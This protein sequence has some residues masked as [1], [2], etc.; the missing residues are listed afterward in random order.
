MIKI[1]RADK[2]TYISNFVVDEVVKDD[3]NVGIAGS[4]NL[5]KLYGHSMS[6]S[7]PLT[8]L[9]RILLHFNLEP[10][11]SLVL[12]GTV[13]TTHSSFQCLLQLRDVYGG[14]PVP[15]SYGI[16]V[17]PLSASFDEGLGKDVVLYS[18]SDEANWLSGSRN[19]P[20][21]TAGC[22]LAGHPD[23]SCDYITGSNA[24]GSLLSTQT[25]PV[26]TEDLSIDVTRI[27][28]GM[29]SNQLPD[30]GFRLSFTSAQEADTATYFVK[31]FGSRQAYNEA[32]RPTL[33]VKFDDSVTDDAQNLTI[34]V[35][36][37]VHLYNYVYGQLT[38]L[39]SSSAQLTGNNVASLR[40]IMEVSGGFH[41]MSFPV[42]QKVIGTSFVSGT[43]YANIVVP[44]SDTVIVA[45]LA[46]SAS[47]KFTPVWSSTDETVSFHTG[48]LLTVKK[49]TT[50][51]PSLAPKK[52]AVSVVGLFDEHKTTDVVPLRLN[53]FDKVAISLQP[54]KKPIDTP[55]L[56]VKSYYAI[57][58]VSTNE[59]V[60][61]FDDEKNSTR[62]S[63]DATGMFFRLD[64]SNLLSARTYVVDIMLVFA[65]EKQIY[66]NASR[67]FKVTQ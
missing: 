30:S 59:Y 46:K 6:G 45:E 24:L 26:G 55:G 60:V 49:S 56:V 37:T 38:N 1:L 43:Y 51:Q 50:S 33:T 58:D 64:F 22:G 4:L 63:S 8:E 52:F 62:V 15:S 5:Y 2:D 23:I 25:F 39:V 21:F 12:S 36:G 41:S 57:R 11:R 13:D 18:D 19:T 42:S 47:L 44:T 35:T 27:V 65:G 3:A 16:N 67:T 17:Y 40:L 10:I 48:S 20:W 61:Q 32:K 28:Y 53:I 7:T 54:V 29:L 14:Q 9:S 34:D 31:R 66:Q